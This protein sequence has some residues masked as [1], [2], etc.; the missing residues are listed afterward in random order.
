MSLKHSNK[1]R[2][3]QL[4]HFMVNSDIKEWSV[5]HFFVM[6]GVKC[7]LLS[8]VTVYLSWLLRLVIKSE[9]IAL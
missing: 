9:H 5:H 8:W 1:L 2:N 7:Y 6:A 4:L 3:L